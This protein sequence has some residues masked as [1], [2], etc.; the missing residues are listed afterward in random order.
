MVNL[1]RANCKGVW[2]DWE[3]SMLEKL[4]LPDV[5]SGTLESVFAVVEQVML[6]WMVVTTS[7]TSAG[8]AVVPGVKQ[9]EDW[10]VVRG[11]AEARVARKMAVRMEGVY[12]FAVVIAVVGRY[13]TKRIVDKIIY[14]MDIVPSRRVVK[15]KERIA[16]KKNEAKV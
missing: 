4:T 12:I 2:E 5:T 10:R 13:K 3:K 6:D 9:A 11:A 1:S 14:T 7:A 8:R 16:E 15:S